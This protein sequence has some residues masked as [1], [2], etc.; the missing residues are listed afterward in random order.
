MS[1]TRWSGDWGCCSSR[2]PYT[3]RP[4][5]IQNRMAGSRL[6]AA[7]LSPRIIEIKTSIDKITKSKNRKFGKFVG[8]SCILFKSRKSFFCG[9]KQAKT[10]KV[11]CFNAALRPHNLGSPWI[12]SSSHLTANCTRYH[13]FFFCTYLNSFYCCFSTI[14]YC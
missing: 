5:D 2:V 6:D 7:N 13:Y 9:G 12:T 1:S 14:L 10:S 3:S 4:L 11:H 8:V